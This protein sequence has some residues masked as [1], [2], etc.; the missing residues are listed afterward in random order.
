[1]ATREDYPSDE[2]EA[3]NQALLLEN[4]EDMPP[5]QLLK[6][7]NYQEKSGLFTAEDMPLVKDMD[8]QGDISM[9]NL[10]DIVAVIPM[11][12]KSVKEPVIALVIVSDIEKDD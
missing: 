11:D 8:I 3:I 7:K 4:L 12:I 2:V 1:M 6:N 10:S 9:E 5:E